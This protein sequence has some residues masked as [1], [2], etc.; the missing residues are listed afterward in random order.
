[1]STAIGRWPIIVIDCPDARSLAEF[2]SAITGWPLAEQSDAEWVQLD[3]GHTSTIGFQ[4][5]AGYR[6]PQWPGQESPQQAHLDFVVDDL[7]DAESRVLA[8]GAFKP[9]HQP[10][11][12]YQVFLDP[13]GHPFCLV[14]DSA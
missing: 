5:V 1:M 8:L 12:S 11:Q 4:Q 10:G 7:L 9:S 13:A 2:Y 14:Q 3:S 6:P